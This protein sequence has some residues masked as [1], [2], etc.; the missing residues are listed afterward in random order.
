MSSWFRSVSLPGSK[1]LRSGREEGG[2]GPQG[3]FRRRRSTGMSGAF[4][5]GARRAFIFAEG[6]KE[7]SGEGFPKGLASAFGRDTL[8]QETGPKP[9]FQYTD[10]SS[11]INSSRRSHANEDTTNQR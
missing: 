10:L 8:Y 11:Y 6:V 9:R 1:C 5:D 4:I 2:V 7:K 3:R